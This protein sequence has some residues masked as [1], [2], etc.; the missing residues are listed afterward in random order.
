MRLLL[1]KAGKFVAGKFVQMQ[2]RIIGGFDGKD[3]RS[4]QGKS[5]ERHF[6]ATIA[7]R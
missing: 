3:T 1:L 5:G 2:H 4:S 6:L 7:A